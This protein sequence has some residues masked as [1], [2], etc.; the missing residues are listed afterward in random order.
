M[1]EFNLVSEKEEQQYKILNEAKQKQLPVNVRS[2]SQKDKNIIIQVI[3]S[4]EE[5]V[6][7]FIKEKA[8]RK[9]PN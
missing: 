3:P 8:Q 1:F 4:T 2:N 6:K 9:D 7:H 5:Q